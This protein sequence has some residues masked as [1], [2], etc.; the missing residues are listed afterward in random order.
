[1]TAGGRGV[2]AAAGMHGVLST[3]PR[4]RRDRPA[5]L[6]GMSN[7]GYIDDATVEAFKQRLLTAIE[8]MTDL[9]LLEL[10]ETIHDTLVRRR[11]LR[12]QYARCQALWV[13]AVEVRA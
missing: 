8:P 5:A 4:N 3:M 7:E 10:A 13:E 1:M 2:K 12:E 6:N 11:D 9:Q